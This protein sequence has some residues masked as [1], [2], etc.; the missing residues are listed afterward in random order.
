MGRL[1]KTVFISY[2]RTNFPWGLAIF[3]D[4]THNGFDV[5]FDFTGIASGDFE[6]VILE[7]IK[8][9]A[10]FIVLLTPSALERCGDPCD[11]LRREIETALEVRRN[12]I[13]L[14]LEN[15]DFG[16]PG[17]GSQ[18]TGDLE[19][20]KGYNGLRV[21]P[22]YFAE[23]MGRLRDRYL[24]VPLDAV[25]HPASLMA[26]RA[27]K[28]QQ[29]VAASAPAVQEEE[30]TAGEWF[31]RGYN[32]SDHDEELRCFSEAIRLKPD[33]ADAFNNRAFARD[34]KGDLEGALQDCNE[35][36]RLKPD[37]AKAF[38]NRGRA[39]RAKGDKEGAIADYQRYLDL[40]GGLRDGDQAEVEKIIRNLKQTKTD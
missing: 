4:L 17:I 40:G 31:E 10:H 16:A 13:P 38:Y 8:A 35:A 24:N 19:S 33:F 7:N 20:L 22:E 25:L 1:E 2:R 3:Q 21:P 23:A 14:M 34:A 27:A 9:R 26:K 30:L 39:R 32:T 36:I 5:F 15:F 37:H 11:W 28:D 18:L 29:A 6:S 12:I